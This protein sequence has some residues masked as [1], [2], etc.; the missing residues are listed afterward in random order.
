[1]W[2]VVP[3]K[4]FRLAKQRLAPLLSETERAEL[5][6]AML[7]DVLAALTATAGVSRIAVVTREPRIRARESG[8]RL[9]VVEEDGGGLV[10]AVAQGARVARAA[11]ATGAIVVP[12]DLPLAT[13]GAL[14]AVLAG[15]RPAP[16]VT[17]VPD[18]E[19]EGT[20]CLA[21][22]PP[23]VIDFR[24]GPDSR[25]AHAAGARR[26]GV[27]AAVVQPPELA[28]DV[29]KPR[30]LRALLERGGRGRTLAFLESSGIASRLRSARR[31]ERTHET[32]GHL[33]ERA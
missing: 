20:N 24:F 25:S 6:A 27:T 32:P 2:A 11:G 33:G 30:D 28:L 3:V 22:S 9:E 19:G 21:C 4:P 15:H 1:V 23:D 10:A 17:I 5:S 14:A 31:S 7:D 18:A 29:D 12:G 26:A 16:A 13:P 8:P